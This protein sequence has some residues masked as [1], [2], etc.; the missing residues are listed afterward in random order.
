MPR[1]RFWITVAAATLCVATVLP[2]CAS[3]RRD[4]ASVDSMLNAW[5]EAA[6]RADAEGYLDV[7]TDDGVFLGTDATEHWSIAEFREFCRPYFEQGIGWTYH[8]RDRRVAFA[9][10]G[11]VAWFEE[12]LDNDKYGEVRGSGVLVRQQGRWWLAQYNMAFPIPNDCSAAVIELI[13]E[14]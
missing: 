7:F 11:D 13:R 9:P 12:R 3:S 1:P 2:S 6:S 8:P 5:H 4:R 10:A 14:R